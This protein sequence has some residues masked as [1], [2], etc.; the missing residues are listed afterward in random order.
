[1]SSETGIPERQGSVQPVS[2]V[3]AERCNASAEGTTRIPVVFCFVPFPSDVVFTWWLRNFFWTSATLHF[4][5]YQPKSFLFF[6]FFFKH[7]KKILHQAH[8]DRQI[9]FIFVGKT[10]WKQHARRRRGF[11]EGTETEREEAR[12]RADANNALSEVHNEPIENTELFGK[13][14]NCEKYA[15]V[16]VE[17]QV[18][19]SDT[20]TYFFFKCTFLLQIRRQGTIIIT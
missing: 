9:C 12:S 11:G 18:G 3:S 1:M 6:Y 20:R 4:P 15:H 13:I 14:L 7:S 16:A 2:V 19:T 10:Q 17:S 8:A 5:G